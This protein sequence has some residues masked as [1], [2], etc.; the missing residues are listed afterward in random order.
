MNM[1]FL[2]ACRITVKIALKTP[3]K[4]KRNLDKFK[5]GSAAYRKSKAVNVRVD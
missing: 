5:I 3:D 1:S 2:A 4:P